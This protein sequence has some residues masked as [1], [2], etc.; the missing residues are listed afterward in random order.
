MLSKKDKEGHS[1]LIKG[2]ISQNELSIPNIYALNARAHMFI[3]ETLLNQK[4]H[5]VPQTMRCMRLQNPILSNGQ[6]MEIKIK[7][8]H[9]EIKRS[10]EP[11]PN[12][13]N[14]YL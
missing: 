6:I 5:I 14:R 3:K 10:Y 2:K 13:F 8:R 9:S 7:Q 12:E 1:I 4:A 11:E